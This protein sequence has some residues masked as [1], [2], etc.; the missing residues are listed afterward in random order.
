MTSQ[1]IS[2]A[3]FRRELKRRKVL[4]ACI[5]YL[6]ACWG[7][8]KSADVI[9]TFLKFD[10]DLASHT[11]VMAAIIGLPI[12]AVFSWFYEVSLAGI[13]RRPG[14]VE[15]RV[16]DNIAPLDDRRKEGPT[17]GRRSRPES[18]YD[19]ILEVETGPLAGQRYGLEG[20]VVIGRSADCDLTIPVPRISRQHARFVVEGN[21]LLLEDL[22]SSNGTSVNGIRITSVVSLNHQDKVEL[23]D[24]T[25][26]IKENLAHFHAQD[27]TVLHDVT[28][29]RSHETLGSAAKSQ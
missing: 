20:S 25:F 24:V 15:R 22:N 18:A 10:P 13:T 28:Q 5:V 17:R 1:T 29:Q 16:L 2:F 21:K 26:K 7:G 12:T 11:V 14:F 9:L 4:R 19:W 23:L 27:A 3:V 6:L 8:L